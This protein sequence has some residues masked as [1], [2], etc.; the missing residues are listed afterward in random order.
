MQ[1]VLEKVAEYMRQQKLT[2]EYLF[3][4]LDKN[5][6]GSVDLDEFK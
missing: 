3:E 4:V 6:N 1:K 2:R 5:C